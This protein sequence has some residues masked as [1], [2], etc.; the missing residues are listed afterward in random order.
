MK[1]KRFK[2]I[3]PS[4]RTPN[5]RY[6]TIEQVVHDLKSEKRDLSLQTYYIECLEDEIEIEADEL[7]RAWDEGERPM[8]LQMF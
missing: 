6:D 5:E 4:G 8:D 2:I 7:L 1:I 3:D